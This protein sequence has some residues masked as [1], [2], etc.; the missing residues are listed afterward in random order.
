MGAR[1]LA[2][3][4]SPEPGSFIFGFNA[5]KDPAE[6]GPSPAFRSGLV[7][8]QSPETWKNMWNGEVFEKGA[9]EVFVEIKDGGARPR[10]D[11]EQLPN[12]TKLLRMEWYVRRK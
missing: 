9:V 10:L 4:L 3:L 8:W 7:F 6:E 12:E 11:F 2:S 5:A 1:A